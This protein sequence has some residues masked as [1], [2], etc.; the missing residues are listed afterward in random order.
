MLV[1]F[2][3]PSRNPTPR[4]STLISAHLCFSERDVLYQGSVDL[5]LVS[6]MGSGGPPQASPEVPYSF[7]QKQEGFPSEVVYP[8]SAL[9]KEHGSTGKADSCGRFFASGSIYSKGV[10]TFCLVHQWTGLGM[11]LGPSSSSHCPPQSRSR[12]LRSPQE[13]ATLSYFT[14]LRIQAYKAPTTEQDH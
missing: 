14:K 7:I 11:L 8:L 13:W 5:L 2:L 1:A 12:N 10:P 3:G 4:N 9:H 6:G